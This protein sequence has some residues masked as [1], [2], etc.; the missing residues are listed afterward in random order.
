MI[1]RHKIPI[2]IKKSN[3]ML[4]CDKQIMMKKLQEKIRRIQ[5]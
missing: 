4:S 1:K 2:H 5:L 3:I